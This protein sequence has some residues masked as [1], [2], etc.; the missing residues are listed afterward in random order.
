[1]NSSSS[2][3][4]PRSSSS[5]PWFSKS[6]LKIL[7]AT[8]LEESERREG[9]ALS[10]R[11][12]SVTLFTPSLREIDVSRGSRSFQSIFSWKSFA[13]SMSPRR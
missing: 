7:E 3:E 11:S 2:D 13:V 5:Y 12:C 8:F 6:P 4:H 1:M 10:L 9:S